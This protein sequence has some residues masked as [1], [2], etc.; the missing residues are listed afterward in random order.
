MDQYDCEQYAKAYRLLADILERERSAGEQHVSFMLGDLARRVFVET[1]FAPPDE[2]LE[3]TSH[4]IRSGD[5]DTRANAARRLR[6][7][8]DHLDHLAT[9]WR[10]PG[11]SV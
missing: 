10:T 5:T 3:E 9:N 1:P 6:E 2:I 7:H 4:V 11:G 8:A